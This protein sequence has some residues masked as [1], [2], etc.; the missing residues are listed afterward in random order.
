[1]DGDGRCF[2]LFFHAFIIYF[3]MVAWNPAWA[4]SR[5]ANNYL[6]SNLVHF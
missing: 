6:F 4:H 3:F 5:Q 1:M 2:A